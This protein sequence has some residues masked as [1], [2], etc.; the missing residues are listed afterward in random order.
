M[1]SGLV[2]REPLNVEYVGTV[3]EEDGRTTEWPEPGPGSWLEF[4]FPDILLNAGTSE[5]SVA[6]YFTLYIR[7]ALHFLEHSNVI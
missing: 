1:V 4:R 3:E 6:K 5:F 7:I 2:L